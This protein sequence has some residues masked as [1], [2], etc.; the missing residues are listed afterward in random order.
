MI[1]TS[2]FACVRAGRR[3]AHAAG[4]S[5][6]ATAAVAALGTGRVEAADFQSTPVTAAVVGEAYSYEVAAS[7]QAE[8]SITAPFG[9]PSWLS[10]V[11]TGN[12]TAVLSGT[13]DVGDSGADIVL[14]AEDT[15]CRV[16]PVL[17][18]DYQ[19][20]DIA[21][22]VIPNDPPIVVAPVADQI[23]V[24]QQPFSLDVSGV[25]S[26]PDDD[27][28]TVSAA[29]LP[30]GFALSGG[31][32]TGTAT[33]ADVV[34]SPYTVLLT[35]D[36]G[37]GGLVQDT[38]VLTIAPFVSADVSLESIEAAP[39]PAAVDTPVEWAFTVANAGPSPAQSLALAIEFAGNPV[40]FGAH[41][42][43][44]SVD[45]D[46]QR[47][48]CTLGP[49]ASGASESVTVSATAAQAGDVFVS[50]E[51]RVDADDPTL[52]DHTGTL[53]LNVGRAIVDEPAQ[54]LSGYAGTAAAHGDL[55][56]DGFDDVAVA[57]LGDE[58][59]AVHLNLENPTA[60]HPSLAGDGDQRRG[61]SGIPLSLGD[62]ST[63]LDAAL[64]DLDNDGAL[65][66]VVGDDSTDAAYRNAGDGSLTLYATFGGDA[67][68]TRAV[69][70]ADLDGDGFGDVAFAN[71]GANTVYL[72][73]S[74]G[75]FAAVVLPNDDAAT[76]VDVLAADLVGSALPDLVFANADG[77]AVLYENLGGSFAAPLIID[78]GPTSSV[79]SGDFNGD[80]AVDLVFG[81]ATPE[82]SGLPS[83]PVY[84]NNGGGD[85]VA[86]E[87]LGATA[88][89]D[90]LTADI[91]ADG[92]MDIVSINA[93]GAHQVF[94]GNGEG[95]FSL[96]PNLFVS[97]G[98]RRGTIAAVGRLQGADVAVAGTSGLEV[99]FNDGRGNLGLGDTDRPVIELLGA[100]EVEIEVG[101]D[102]DDPGATATDDLDGT[103]TPTA[104]GEV[105]ATVVGMYTLTYR[106]LDAAGNAAVP[107]TRTVR[108]EA[109]AADGGGG[110]A[111]G[112]AAVAVLL[113]LYGACLRRGH[114]RRS[115][116]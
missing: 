33:A 36:D 74:S 53:G 65:D 107:V 95:D 84:L 29:G 59:T 114:H 55:D 30:V 16:L 47:L 85:F 94:V 97:R 13:P 6:L 42:C 14:R 54:T 77:A 106:A 50:A 100:P 3:V 86:V 31:L 60:L 2:A 48:D 45:G 24:E 22:A 113:L 27:P 9:L 70:A 72:N 90:V 34:G 105:D 78:A 57:T 73:R 51:V 25:F 88:T 92:A 68:D 110:G 12:G 80:G 38:F 116:T 18:F 67:T 52:D 66:L 79:A 62:T 83:N 98:A 71:A 111:M 10:L 112:W 32:V 104:D 19:E 17:C 61:L 58:P 35:A 5:L 43:T 44:Q 37:R 8:V 26:D 101:D 7:G 76:S 91:D 87:R 102:Y 40:T 23:A 1:S 46:R 49:I 93:T 82:A 96:R 21:I 81:R 103:L 41:P 108:V 4:V 115:D 69:A 63:G 20:F 39:S 28:L 99:F 109:R 89:L 15:A 11:P 56:D 64:V 75:D